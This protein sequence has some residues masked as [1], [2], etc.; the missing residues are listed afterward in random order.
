MLGMEAPLENGGETEIPS[1]KSRTYVQ[2]SQL[3]GTERYGISWRAI[4]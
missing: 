3:P 2:I 4:K 1:S